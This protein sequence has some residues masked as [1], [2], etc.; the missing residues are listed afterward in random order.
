MSGA[1][2]IKGDF[3]TDRW[4]VEDRTTEA[5]SYRVEQSTLVRTLRQA[6]TSRRLPQWRVTINEGRSGELTVRLLM[7][8]DYLALMERLEELERQ[9]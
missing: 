8:K 1:G 5:A 2:R 4:L 3:Q 9:A 7:E 6:V